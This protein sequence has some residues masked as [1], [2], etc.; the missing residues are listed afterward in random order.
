MLRTH[1]I[2][3]LVGFAPTLCFGRIAAQQDASTP[4]PVG[5]RQAEQLGEFEF[6][7]REQW[8]HTLRLLRG[9]DGASWRVWWEL[10]RDEYLHLKDNVYASP[11]VQGSDECYL[12]PSPAW[13]CEELRPSVERV[14]QETLPALFEVLATTR[15]ASITQAS[16]IAAARSGDEQRRGAIARS[17]E[18]YLGHANEDVAASAVLALGVLGSA[19]DLD[20]LR[21]VLRD[22]VEALAARRIAVQGRISMRVRACAGYALGLLARG[23]DSATR[24]R[25]ASALMGGIS[26]A[27]GSS[28]PSQVAAACALAIGLVPLDSDLFAPLPDA[29]TQR[30]SSVRS[31]EEQIVSLSAALEQRELP[32]QVRAQLPTSIARL[33]ARAPQS[34]AVREL[35]TRRILA[36]FSGSDRDSAEVRAGCAIALG[37]I[38][39]SDQDRLDVDVRRALEDALTN[40]SDTRIRCDVMLALARVASR[41]GVGPGSFASLDNGRGDPRAVLLDQLSRGTSAERAH[42]ALALGV[43][44]HHVASVRPAPS[45][46]VVTALREALARVTEGEEAGA[47][48]L[49]LGLARDRDASPLLLERLA[50]AGQRSSAGPLALALGLLGET[51][52]IAALRKLVADATFDPAL[53]RDAGTALALL[54][55]KDVVPQLIELQR[56]TSSVPA[57]SAIL[58]TLGEIGDA[59][60][61]AT[62]VGIVRDA[63]GQPTLVRA[64]AAAALGTCSDRAARPW[65]ALLHADTNQRASVRSELAFEG[66]AGAFESD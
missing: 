66:L 20:L 12:A 9:V 47:L 23:A 19:H 33:L 2:A 44:E 46:R 24:T 28:E 55:D 61:L 34:A 15:S 5:P 18:P 4:G 7:S 58:A 32:V 53:L 16:L 36:A 63:E 42:A 60:A 29:H 50:A 51:D 49:A 3:A 22:D 14:V 26:C 38:G 39:D 8:I 10:H 45:V 59:R 25:A 48:A 62:L 57:R 31:L 64:F 35:A 17:I 27:N 40:E 54:G 6:D 21:A 52:A 65:T 43:L 11:V 56:G 1:L 30:W 37:V 41:A 13:A